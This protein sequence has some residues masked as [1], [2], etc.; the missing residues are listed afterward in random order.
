MKL[1]KKTKAG[2]PSRYDDACG[3]AH[4]LEIFGDRWALLIM[5]EL[6]LGPRRFSQLR[7]DLPGISASILTQRLAD[8]ERRKVLVKTR[9]PPP[10][11]TPV[12]E[13]TEWGYEAEP[14][15]S[16]MGRWAAR[17][18]SHDPGRPI[19]GVSLLLSFRTMLDRGRCGDL[20]ACLGFQFGDDVYGAHLTGSGL[21][22][23]QGDPP[24]PRVRFA[25]TP[26]ALG[27]AV[28]GKVPLARLEAEGALR[29][30]GDRRLAQRFVTLFPLPKR[31]EP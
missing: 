22:V 16:A 9:L 5:R 10:A 17:S 12:Y 14:I 6:M 25:G 30:S 20:D 27:A 15:T 24:D 7:A 31:F 26:M 18:P 28:Y 21:S 1:K 4:A 23:T 19:S 11:A 3:T 8:L 2:G 29:I 13:L